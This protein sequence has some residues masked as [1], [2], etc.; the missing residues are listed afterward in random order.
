MPKLKLAFI[1]IAMLLSTS[2]CFAEEGI[3]VTA[4]VD[5]KEIALD[6]YIGYTIKIEGISSNGVVA[7]PKIDLPKLEKDFYVIAN[8][9]SNE[10]N[11]QSGKSS[12]SW[13]IVYTLLPKR[14]GTINI[15]EAQVVFQKKTYKTESIAIKVGHANNP[16]NITPKQAPQK[17]VPWSSR[18]GVEI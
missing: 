17:E 7:N 15:G 5:K 12:I 8:S 4:S 18:E 16:Q 6:E 9:Q 10:I 13:Q 11:W 3:A 14:E 1:F 2:I